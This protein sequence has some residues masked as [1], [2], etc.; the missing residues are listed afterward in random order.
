[1]SWSQAF[2]FSMR[3]NIYSNMN[4]SGREIL[5]FILRVSFVT[6]RHVP[7]SMINYCFSSK[8][9]KF[10]LVLRLKYRC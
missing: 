3:V 10:V 8:K 5:F 9:F 2:Y 7:F 4:L 1:M 6:K